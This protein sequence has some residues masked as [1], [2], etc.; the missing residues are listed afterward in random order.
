MTNAQK[1]KVGDR[2]VFEG[3]LYLVLTEREGCSHGH[4][5]TIVGADAEAYMNEVH[6]HELTVIR[7]PLREAAKTLLASL[8]TITEAEWREKHLAGLSGDIHSELNYIYDTETWER[9]Q[10]NLEDWRNDA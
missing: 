7:V 10:R 9:H 2:V 1:F 6:E 4:D 8:E 5:Y 3:N